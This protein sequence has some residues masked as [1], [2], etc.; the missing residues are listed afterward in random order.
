MV[1]LRRIAEPLAPK[2]TGHRTAAPD[3]AANDDR[4][5]SIQIKSDA[6]IAGDGCGEGGVRVYCVAATKP[7]I[8]LSDCSFLTMLARSVVGSLV[9]AT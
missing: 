9:G 4:I 5:S 6:A 3:G 1:T 2:V 7:T 8:V